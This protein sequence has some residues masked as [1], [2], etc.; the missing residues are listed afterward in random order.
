MRLSHQLIKT[1]KGAMQPLVRQHAIQTRHRQRNQEQE[2]EERDYYLDQG[3]PA[4][5]LHTS[6]YDA[7]AKSQCGRQHW[8]NGA[9]ECWSGGAAGQWKSGKRLAPHSVALPRDRCV[10]KVVGR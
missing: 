3:K 10:G 1:I 8:S 2:N 7:C 9:M 5:A 6:F 4:L